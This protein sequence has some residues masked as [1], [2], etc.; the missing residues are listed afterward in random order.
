MKKSEK[1]AKPVTVV[2]DCNLT[3]AWK[4]ETTGYFKALE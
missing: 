1:A 3:F 4:C 2:Q